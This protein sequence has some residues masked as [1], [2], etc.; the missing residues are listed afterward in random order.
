MPQ[1]NKLQNFQQINS[2][3]HHLNKF[4]SNNKILLK[5]RPG[6]GHL[7]IQIQKVLQNSY[8]T[9]ISLSIPPQFQILS[10]VNNQLEH[11]NG[12]EFV[13]SKHV[14]QLRLSNNRFKQLDA[15]PLAEMF[16]QL[17][18][19]HLD[20]NSFLDLPN[21]VA[22]WPREGQLEKI[23]LGM[24][25]FRCD[26]RTQE[27]RFRAQEWVRQNARL[28]VDLKQVLCVENVTR[29][30]KTNDTAVLSDQPPNEGADLF[31]MPMIEFL[32][33]SFLLGFGSVCW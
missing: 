25:P 10:I 29:A 16:P 7:Q 26:C 2:N 18:E 31:V 6:S 14:R 24:N 27:D 19:L 21:A 13:K 28:I 9:K 4:Q 20:E 3:K 15:Q 5:L 33:V 32:R 1:F 12:T 23:R 11:L 22:E 8:F 30:L 17:E